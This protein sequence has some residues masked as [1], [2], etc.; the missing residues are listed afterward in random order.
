MDSKET[1][2][3]VKFTAKLV[4]RTIDGNY[5]ANIPDDLKSF[6]HFYDGT[7]KGIVE[8]LHPGMYEIEINIK[9]VE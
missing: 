9:S 3:S 5:F 8:N 7:M 1:N 4:E 2:A 6:L